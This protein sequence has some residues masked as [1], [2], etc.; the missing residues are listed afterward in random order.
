MLL[1]TQ[2]QGLGS[3]FD[4]DF[5]AGVI[6]FSQDRFWGSV[7]GGEGCW[8]AVGTSRR[9][10]GAGG[11]PQ[12]G[13]PVS[14]MIVWPWTSHSPFRSLSFPPENAETDGLH[15]EDNMRPCLKLLSIRP[16]TSFIH[17]TSIY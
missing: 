5:Q 8:G 2:S 9:E 13:R 12:A 7:A 1:I 17:S 16:D 4:V 15:G 11:W 3:N 10:A 14:G 6:W